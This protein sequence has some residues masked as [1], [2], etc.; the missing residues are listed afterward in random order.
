M[1]KAQ[2]LGDTTPLSSAQ[3]FSNDVRA[4]IGHHN[5]AFLNEWGNDG[6]YVGWDEELDDSPEVRQYIA[7]ETLY[8]PNGGETNVEGSSLASIV[9]AYDTTM[10]E[11]SRYHW[12][13][14]GAEYS[15]DVTNRWR[16]N[17]TFAEM[18]RRLGYRY[19]L[20]SATLPETAKTGEQ[21]TIQ[22]DIRNTGCAPLYNERH[23]YIVLRNQQS[24]FRIQLATDPRRW[25]PNGTV[26]T[27]NEQIDLPS[28]MPAGTY[29]LY[30]HLPDASATLADDPRYAIRFAN[31]DVWDA[32][33]G[34][35]SLNASVVLQEGTS[36]LQEVETS[37]DTQAYDLLG[38]PVNGHYHGIVI[39]NRQKRIQ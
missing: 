30:L 6:T 1:I 10:A 35:N 34:M 25:L 22:I 4:R 12:S 28:D 3:A 19:Q 38:R 29:Q 7:D 36:D 15:E 16:N 21:A 5:D 33:T 37:L 31:T 11:L 27:I 13:F 24:T 9:A 8:V 17:G 26:T 2:Y 23:A 18:Q 20:V 32:A 14:C 39:Q